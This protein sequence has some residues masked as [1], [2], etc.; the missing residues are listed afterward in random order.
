MIS[1]TP[2]I[3][4]QDTL[5]E[6]KD[7]LSSVLGVAANKIKLSRDGVGFLRDEP[8]LAHYNVAPNVVLS[9]GTKERTRGKKG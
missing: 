6:F 8:S 2:C 7:R 1:C 9:L 3:P 5:G 4:L